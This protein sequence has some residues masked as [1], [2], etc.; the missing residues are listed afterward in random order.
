[1]DCVRKVLRRSS[2]SDDGF[3]FTCD[4]NGMRVDIVGC[5]LELHFALSEREYWLYAGQFPTG[6]S[7]RTA[8]KNDLRLTF[9]GSSGGKWYVW[10]AIRPKDA[11]T[12]YGTGD[13]ETVAACVE[14]DAMRL[15]QPLPY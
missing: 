10:V 6:R 9:K 5:Q 15:L 4:Q 2:D 11:N 3:I 12:R 7:N 14:R 1:M 13:V 8:V